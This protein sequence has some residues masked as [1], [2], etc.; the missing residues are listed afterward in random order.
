[1]RNTTTFFMML[2]L[3]LGGVSQLEAQSP[4]WVFGVGT[5]LGRITSEGSQGFNTNSAGP[6]EADFDLSAEDFKDL[7]E[8]GFGLATFLNN[9]T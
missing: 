7:I 6:L 1:M 9:G 5:G 4:P 2:I 8:T 3:Y